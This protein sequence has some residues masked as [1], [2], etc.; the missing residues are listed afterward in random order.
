MLPDLSI[1]EVVQVHWV[2]QVGWLVNI[3]KYEYVVNIVNVI[4]KAD[5]GYIV[6]PGQFRGTF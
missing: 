4:T 5:F 3:N 1:C 2:I 6:K